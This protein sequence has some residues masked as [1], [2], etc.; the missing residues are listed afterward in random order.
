MLPALPA[1]ILTNV[2][3]FEVGQVCKHGHTSLSITEGAAEAAAL[4]S[5]VS[6]VPKET[7]VG[8]LMAA[9][10]RRVCPTSSLGH[11]SDAVGATHSRALSA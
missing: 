4:L 10:T 5:E 11:T 2:L 9:C 1:R 6:E 3:H 8:G 7:A